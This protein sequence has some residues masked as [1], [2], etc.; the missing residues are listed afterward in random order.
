MSEKED[1]IQE[2]ESTINSLR[3]NISDMEA[4]VRT[5]EQD[6]YKL[7]EI[8]DRMN[9]VSLHQCGRDHDGTPR[10][11]QGIPMRGHPL[12]CGVDSSHGNLY[13]WFDGKRLCLLCPDCDYT[14]NNA[15]IF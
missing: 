6:G 10:Q 4:K 7:Q 3:D 11:Y 9:A 14:Q 5:L 2:L 15:A 8:I 1:R 12:T 13:P